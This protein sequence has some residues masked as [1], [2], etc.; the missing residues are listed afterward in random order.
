M[1]ARRRAN[2]FTPRI[3]AT[4]CALLLG[5]WAAAGGA[6]AQAVNP[7]A[8]QY[9]MDVSTLRIAGK[10]ENP[11]LSENTL[12]GPSLGRRLELSIVTPRKP[13]GTQ[14]TQTIPAGMGMGSSLTLLP[15]PADDTS[16]WMP[17][18]PTGRILLY[19]GCGE[20]VGSGQPQILDA[21]RMR[22]EEYTQFLRG[23]AGAERSAAATSGHAAWSS[24]Q[25]RQQIP[26]T[27]SLQGK[28]TVSGEGIPAG[29]Q[30][31]LGPAE[32][33]LPPLDISATG[34]LAQSVTL[35]W[36][37]QTQARAYFF[38]A[39]G[40][41]GEDM[42]IWSS[43]ESPE[44]GWDLMGYQSPAQLAQWLGEKTLLPASQTTC[45]IP[46]GIFTK[47]KRPMVQGIAY[48]QGLNLVNPTTVQNKKAAKT[49]EWSARVRVISV[50][51]LPLERGTP[52]SKADRKRAA[53]PATPSSAPE[54]PDDG[55]DQKGLLPMVP[56]IP[57]F[58]DALKGLFGR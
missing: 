46:S 35:R 39:L 13:A 26:A 37:A 43:A 38:N 16:A 22:S 40:A 53:S 57:G 5:G 24:I 42:V 44:P 55:T 28:H 2:A 30:F 31:T 45:A 12:L 8:T 9:E 15:A 50:T 14:A 47:S 17:D 34:E 49:P 18:K 41:S 11:T 36:T 48:G 23:R 27:A 25:N 29:L 4:A 33:F 21:G 7:S 54:N 51:M 19:W 1:P 3:S 52:A 58:S 10:D 32:D 20:T 6:Q 56:G